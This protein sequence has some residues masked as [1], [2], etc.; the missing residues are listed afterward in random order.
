MIETYIP[1]LIV[2]AIGVVF[3]FA[4]V[5]SSVIFGPQRP[6]KEKNSTYESGMKPVGTTHE[7]IS[8]KYYLVAMMFIIFDLEVI[9]IYPWAVQFKRLFNEFG[10]SVFYSMLIFLIVLE[11]GYLYV[12]K[13]GGFKWD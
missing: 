7:R 2:L 12:Y 3:A 13:K 6:N 4:T 9:F 11:L 1:I 8:L 5:M 10:I